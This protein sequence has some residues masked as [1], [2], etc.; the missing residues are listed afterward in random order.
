[1]ICLSSDAVLSAS[2]TGRNPLERFVSEAADNSNPI[3]LKPSN[4]IIEFLMNKKKKGKTDHLYL[5]V[6]YGLIIHWHYLKN[7]RLSRILPVKENIL[8][9]ELIRIL[10]LP[11]C[12]T[13]H[14]CGWLNNQFYGEF[15]KKDGRY[16]PFDGNFSQPVGWSSYQIYIWVK[17][18]TVDI[19]SENEKFPNWEKIGNLMEIIDKS[20]FNGVGG[21]GVCH[22]SCQ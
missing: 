13:A 8:L 3:S 4:A 17:E 16:K 21:G 7:T 20:A 10:A 18:N 9:S 6:E 19:L 15:D 1:M 5:L 12:K 11:E 14:E 2:D 22:Y